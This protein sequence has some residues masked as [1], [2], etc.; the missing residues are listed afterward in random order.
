LLK[1]HVAFPDYSWAV[2]V[3][4]EVPA[5]VHAVVVDLGL[6][7]VGECTLEKEGARKAHTTVDPNN[8]LVCREFGKVGRSSNS[9]EG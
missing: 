4:L 6:E 5:I 1:A 8:A 3:L 9:K 2:R 7:R